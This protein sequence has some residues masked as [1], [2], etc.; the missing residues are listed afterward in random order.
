V[1]SPEGKRAIRRALSRHDARHAVCLA[2][3]KTAR[4]QVFGPSA[5]HR[6]AN[7]PQRAGGYAS[8]VVGH[9]DEYTAPRATAGGAR[10][11]VRNECA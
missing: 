5:T 4:R 6:D 11:S 10:V 3:L 9:A 7:A 2:V 8:E 1:P